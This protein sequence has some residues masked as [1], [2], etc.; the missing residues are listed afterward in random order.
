MRYE[1]CSVSTILTHFIEV[2][3]LKCRIYGL[4]I[5]LKQGEIHHSLSIIKRQ[6]NEILEN[7][8]KQE[9]ILSTY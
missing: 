5:L 9:I 2:T 7:I 4:R 8:L 6:Q 3:P 1:A